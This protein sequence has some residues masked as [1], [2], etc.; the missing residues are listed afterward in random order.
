MLPLLGLL[1]L[2]QLIPPLRVPKLGHE[3]RFCRNHKY[4]AT[5][6]TNYNRHFLQFT[7]SGRGMFSCM[8]VYTHGHGHSMRA[9]SGG[10][11]KR[12]I[13]I[14]FPYLWRKNDTHDYT[15]NRTRRNYRKLNIRV[16]R[17]TT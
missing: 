13:F 11:F 10:V 7:R 8:H 14:N 5:K 2:V 15:D 12:E 4:I 17:S 9:Q 16:F 3:L 6:S 1:E